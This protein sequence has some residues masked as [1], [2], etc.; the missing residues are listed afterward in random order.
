MADNVQTLDV[1]EPGYITIGRDSGPPVRYP[2]SQLLRVAD[3][4][5]GLTH[6]QVAGLSLLGNLCA[7]IIRTL[8]DRDILDETFA[9]SLGMD[10]DLDH[11][12]YALEQLGG[13][14]SDPNFDNVEDA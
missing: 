2:V 10:W 12:I 13:S 6:T 7:I 4:P 11:I 5:V 14:Y 9:D 3:V 8:I 1:T